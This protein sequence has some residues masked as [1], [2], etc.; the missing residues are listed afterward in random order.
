LDRRIQGLDKGTYTICIGLEYIPSEYFEH[1]YSIT[2]TDD[3]KLVNGYIDC[4]NNLPEIHLN[5][6]QN[7]NK[8]YVKALN[9]NSSLIWEG[10]TNG[11][12]RIDNANKY[13]YVTVSVYA[14]D[15][16]NGDIVSYNLFIDDI[17]RFE[18]YLELFRNDNQVSLSSYGGIPPYNIEI[19]NPDF[20]NFIDKKIEEEFTNE[21]FDL[22]N[23]VNYIR[24]NHSEHCD[25]EFFEKVIL[26]DDYKL[27]PNPTSDEA[28]V[29]FPK[30]LN[31]NMI[32]LKLFD[33]SGKL[34]YQKQGNHHSNEIKLNISHL[35]NA[36]YILRLFEYHKPLSWS[37]KLIKK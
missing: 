36:V 37:E 33:T 8:Y 9:E 32:T 29:F 10:N 19:F 18:T 11:Y 14:P 4:L 26:Y 21:I 24:I 23:G 5:L 28:F 3:K 13:E 34:V 25:D 2:I 27:F 16:L 6:P 7:S 1:C 31:P 35:S 22:Y 30:N 20:G 15:Y 17:P 12:R